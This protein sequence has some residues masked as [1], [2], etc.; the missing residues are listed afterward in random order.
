MSQAIDYFSINHPLRGFTSKIALEAR[1]KIFSYFMNIMKPTSECNILDVGITPDSK[2]PDSNFFERYYPYKNNLVTTSIED[3]SFITHQFPGI[4]FVQTEKYGLPFKDKAFDIVFCSAVLEHVGNREY[5]NQFVKELL[6]VSQRFF[7]TTPNRQFPLEVHTF[8]PFLHW[9]P[10]RI[11][12]SI[13]RS[14]GIDFWSRTENL[15]L[16]TP[17]SMLSLF[18]KSVSVNLRKHYLLGMPSNLMAYGDS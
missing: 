7:I 12:Q 14:L 1:K 17:Q 16:L 2:L 13:L 10:Q 9:F 3:A 11:H 8:L 5:Q 18:H 4:A 6:R 15:N